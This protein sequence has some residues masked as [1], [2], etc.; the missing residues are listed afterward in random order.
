L[1]ISPA[2][3]DYL[4][5]RRSANLN[6]EPDRKTGIIEKLAPGTTLRLL[7]N[8]RQ[9]HGY[10][11]AM[12]VPSG[13]TGWIYRTLVRR[14]AGDI[15]EAETIKP[16]DP[17][18]DPT[19]ILTQDERSYASRH[20]RLGKPQAVYERV[21]QGYVLAQDSSLKIPL[22]VQYEIAPEELDGPEERT[23]NFQPDTTIPYGYRSELSDYSGSGFDRGHM[24]PA[25]DM[26][27]NRQAMAESFLLSNISPQVEIGFNRHI[28]KNLESAV[29]GWVRQRGP[30][31]IITGPVFAVNNNRVTYQVI[32]ANHVA[33]PTHFFKI[34]V[35]AKDIENV[36]A[37]A[38]MLPNETLSERTFDEFL[39]PIDDIE[40][41]TGLD[42]LSSLPEAV[43][44]KIESKKSEAVW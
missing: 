5:V 16:C 44:R 31:V 43:Q 39:A 12:G 22:W 41:A 19:F 8:G 37:L 28:W 26:K 32:G 2:L 36:E 38:F 27:R 25:G 10:Y 3:A 1:C 6:V 23:E 13:R 30:L 4:E 42:F 24:A 18:A 17:L 34:V 15:P 20:L 14:H 40:R 35:D 29:R 33:V 11:R 21:R 7:D 9:T